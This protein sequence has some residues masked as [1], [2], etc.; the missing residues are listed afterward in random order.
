MFVQL[1]QPFGDREAGDVIN[2]PATL[3]RSLIFEG[4]AVT[5]RIKSSQA[6]AINLE[7]APK[8]AIQQGPR[9]DPEKEVVYPKRYKPL[10]GTVKELKAWLD[11]HN[12][13]YDA[14]AKKADLIDLIK[15]Q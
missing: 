12:V 6:K 1:T 4:K 7:K 3:A 15:S 13:A 8:R 10:D 5:G 9:P 2:V 11:K 14:R